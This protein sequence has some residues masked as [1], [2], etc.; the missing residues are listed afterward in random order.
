MKAVVLGGTGAVGELLPW[1]TSFCCEMSC[2]QLEARSTGL[3]LV[4]QLLQSAAW[5]S[6]TTVGRREVQVPV[7]YQ[8]RKGNIVSLLSTRL[9]KYLCSCTLM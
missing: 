3:E 6:V 1:I 4:G 2:I 9:A 7:F 5:S 8:V